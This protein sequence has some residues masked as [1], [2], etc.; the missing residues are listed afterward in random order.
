MEHLNS[1]VAP[2]TADYRVLHS[3]VEALPEPCVVL[4]NAG[5][6]LAANTAWKEL[7]RK[8][9]AAEAARNPLGID[10]LT[11][12]RS[13]TTDETVDRALSG[14]EAVLM[15]ERDYYE[16]EYLRPTP[17]D[18]RWFRMTVRSWRQHD[19][20]AII[21]HRDITAEKLG[22][23]SSPTV[24]QEFRALADSAPAMIW[25][26]G[27]D[28][29]CI[30]VSRKWLEF[31]GG[32]PEDALG[33]GWPRFVHP[34]DRDALFEV[35]HTAFEQRVEFAHEYRLRHKDG[36]YRWVRDSGSPRFDA[37]HRFSGF[38]GSVWDLSE[39]KRAAEEASRVTQYAH[40]VRDIAEIANSATTMRE[41]LQ[42]SVD[43]I[44]ETMKFPGGHA[45]LI[46]DDEPG[47]AKPSHVVHIQD[48]ER[49]AS[50][51]DI[52][53]RMTWPNDLGAPGEVMRS[54]KPFFGDVLNEMKYPDR[55][56]RSRACFEAGLLGSV[57][58]PILVD[59]KVEAILEFGCE[60][61]IAAD[62][63][64]KGALISATERLSRF[65]ERRRAQIKFLQQKEEL[66]TSAERLFAM[67][68]RLVDWQEEVGRL[69]QVF[70]R[71][72]EEQRLA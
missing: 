72:F 65:F 56:P 38:T 55:F 23:A 22:R 26:S 57:L 32:R 10:Y 1:S 40:L 16:Q 33:E 53:S 71:Q 25:M 11:L 14:I 48:P 6:V 50:L 44:C 5:L 58:L 45:L 60:E 51:V 64:A 68:G 67:A 61:S 36:G 34:E 29:A 27:P 28:M 9:E 4:D 17:H 3:F 35:F 13:S 12:F 37:M 18:L 47:L 49:M 8:D 63:D 31:T 30:F 43:T 41:A 21:F 39:Q 70:Q 46:H 19:T 66:H 42:R 7:P 2:P 24:E 54:A 69:P 59:D 15:G 62:Q 52:S 20:N